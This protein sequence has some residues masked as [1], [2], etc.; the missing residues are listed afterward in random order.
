V[1]TSPVR[2]VTLDGLI[3]VGESAQRGHDVEAVTVAEGAGHG[4]GSREL[5]ILEC[6][7]QLTG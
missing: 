5:L 6:R 3:D 2:R 1:T 7:R 4:D